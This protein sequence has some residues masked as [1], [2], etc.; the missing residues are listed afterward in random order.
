MYNNQI[1]FDHK[2][3]HPKDPGDAYPNAAFDAAGAA[4]LE[5]VRNWRGLML[6]LGQPGV[7]KSLLLRRCMAA[8][9]EVQ[10]ATISH[11]K[12][13][14]PDILNVLGASLGLGTIDT[15]DEQ[16]QTQRVQ[17]ALADRTTRGQVV[18]LVID[19]AHQ[20]TPRTLQRLSEFGRNTATDTGQQLPVILAGWPEL[21]EKLT[22]AGLGIDIPPI[23]PRLEPLSASETGSFI[24]HQLRQVGRED[25][26]DS[27]SSAV[28]ERIV[29]YG[30][31]IPR[32][33]AA[34]CDAM[35]LLAGL[36]SGRAVDP[37]LVDEAAQSFLFGDRSDT[38][39][40]V[41]N[42][43]PSTARPDSAATEDSEQVQNLRLELDFPLLEA[44]A[45]A[46]QDPNL[47]F[48]SVPLGLEL[49]FN[50]DFGP[51]H[52]DEPARTKPG[53]PSADPDLEVELAIP[54][55]AEPI[56]AATPR[57][58][59]P[60]EL[61]QVL[62][63]SAPELTKFLHLID[64]ISD[65]LSR[66]EP[67][68]TEVFRGFHR[69]LVGALAQVSPQSVLPWE[70]RV[71][72]LV[73]GEASITIAL[74]AT[75]RVPAE[76]GGVLS[77]LLINPGWWQCREI[78]V[79]LRG[80]GISFAHQ[81][82]ARSLRLLDGRQGRAVHLDYQL[83]AGSVQETATLRMELDVLDHR[84]LWHA[85][86]SP[87]LR[88]AAASLEANASPL[89]EGVAAE[90]IWPLADHTGQVE[91]GFTL[92]LNLQPDAERTR[93]LRAAVPSARQNL[94][95]T[96][97]TPL[98]RALL[99]GA[100]A[101]QAPTRIELVARP[102]LTLGRYNPATGAG[103][104]DFSLGFT[105][106]PIRISRLHAVICVLG[107]QWCLMP[108]TERG[109]TYTGRNG[110]RLTRGQWYP[111]EADDCLDICGLYG[112][113][114]ELAWDPHQ[115]TVPVPGWNLEEPRDKFGRY[116]MDLVRRLHQGDRTHDQPPK[117]NDLRKYYLN[118]LRIQDRAARIN[119][120]GNPGA[121]LYAR[122]KRDDGDRQVA[123]YYVPK[124]LSLGSDPES[125]L[126]I[127]ATNV[128]P[129]HADLLFREGM[130]WIQNLAEAG[131]VQVGC[132]A[133]ENQEVLALEAGDTLSIG[134][135]RFEFEAY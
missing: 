9:P 56:Q 135:A 54:A 8:A 96:R 5:G 131:S 100:D 65:R 69:W 75:A 12:P 37:A 63:A 58:E 48:N 59:I 122:L 64:D 73:T 77:V 126:L 29:Q 42:P 1:G 51:P 82:Q 68:D 24:R 124:W 39:L 87:E 84:G 31:G 67:R 18:A 108:M 119:G 104:G 55:M 60:P 70:Q 120:V 129:F 52:A 78:R 26:A 132:H 81:G 86:Q 76:A 83:E 22:Q 3:F 134:A 94:N 4:L 92:P 107:D 133:L 33:I 38:T 114:L 103:L 41:T 62:E 125:G 130:F 93:R 25:Q 50:F 127:S 17:L 47:D 90:L 19:D 34:V 121:L 61:V 11:I 112:L 2:P 49:D 53:T 101:S 74:A 21:A 106:D 102:F 111:L 32:T 16:E 109:Q 88:W 98:S 23:C 99:L 116:V 10:F 36:E 46:H 79:H 57:A 105:A 110:E 35:L 115:E 95:F 113:K 44:D 80:V 30:Q 13:D 85:Y 7:G 40:P 128:A 20:L 6:L 118:L 14:W 45:E 117:Q 27:L 89:V 15:E 71:V 91:T 66:M 123:H 97:G 72:Q 28:I 43:G